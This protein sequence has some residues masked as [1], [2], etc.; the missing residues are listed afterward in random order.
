[1]KGFTGQRTIKRWLFLIRSLNYGGAERQL[2]VLVR[3]LHAQGEEVR[4]A[5]FYRGGP[6]EQEL[7]A[8][9]IS[10]IA[11][12]KRGRWD[13]VRFFIRLVSV[14]KATQPEILH[15]YLVDS[16]LLAVMV[17]LLF[18]QI[19]VIW[20]VRASAMDLNHY[21]KVTRLAFWLSCRLA[22]FSDLIVTNS[23]AGFNDH[24]LLGYPAHKMVVISNGIDTEVFQPDSS[25]RANIRHLWGIKESELLVGLVARLDPMKDHK[26][27][28]RAVMQVVQQRRDIRF[29][30][31]GDG[32]E[33]YRRE[34]LALSSELGVDGYLIWAKALPI[35]CA[36]FNALE[37]LVLS[38]SSGE[39]FPNVVGEAMACGIPCVVTD[40]G[41]AARIVGNTGLVVPIGDSS[42]LAEGILRLI[43]KGIE[44]NRKWE[45]R[46]R[47]LENFSKDRLIAQTYAVVTHWY[48]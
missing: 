28:I 47:V 35:G 9:G 23:Y 24:Q 8:S 7:V 17:K 40:V 6:L 44:P 37:V 27:F 29:I 14:V 16:N 3:A 38:S 41:D 21:D 26:T 36:V 48:S 15:A 31:V 30:C 22:R 11:L 4:V 43:N 10:V 33:D 20:G 34:L 42:Q 1:M 5:V 12:E 45:I 19:R 25:Q 46:K 13:M 39:G 2:V 32:P 18:P